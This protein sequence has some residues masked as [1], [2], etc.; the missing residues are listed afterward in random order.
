[1]MKSDIL[2]LLHT[3]KNYAN[4]YI[5][6]GKFFDYIKSDK[7]I[8]G[9]GDSEL[10]F[11]K[12]IKKYNLGYSCENKELEIKKIFDL[13]LRNRNNLKR[14]SSLNINKFS[15]EYQNSKLNNFVFN[16]RSK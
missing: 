12:L 16:K 14:K 2:M 1:M 10:L 11:N 15:R 7:I 6:T 13:I 4:K 3:E 8:W 5:Y 9:I